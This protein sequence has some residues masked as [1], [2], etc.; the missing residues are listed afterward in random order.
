[1]RLAERGAEIAC[2]GAHGGEALVEAGDVLGIV[3]DL[4]LGKPREEIDELRL[5]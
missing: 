4:L 3:E 1:V 5:L 2:G